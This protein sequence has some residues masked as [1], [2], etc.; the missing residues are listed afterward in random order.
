MLIQKCILYWS[1]KII[2]KKIV[3]MFLKARI[4]LG[5]EASYLGKVEL[6]VFL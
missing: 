3:N 1:I 4:K 2:L 5:W 6:E